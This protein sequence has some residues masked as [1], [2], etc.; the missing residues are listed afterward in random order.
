MSTPRLSD[1]TCREAAE[2][3]RRNGGNY[4]YGSREL[5]IARSTYQNRVRRA[6]E[7]GMLGYAPVLPGYAVTETAVQRD[8]KG[9]VQREWVRQKREPGAEF[10]PPE[11]HLIKG[12]SALVDPEGRTIAQWVKTR[13]DAQQRTALIDAI[14]EELKSYKATAKPIIVPAN[15]V[16]DMATVYAIGDHHLGLYTWGKETEG[17]DY[18]LAKGNKILRESME[19]LV[20]GVPSASTGIVLNLGDFIHADNQQNRTERSGNALDV[21][22]RYAKVLQVGVGLL[23]HCVELAARKH[24]KVIVRCLPGNHDP[25]TSLALSIALDKYFSKNPQIEV[26]CSPSPF[27]H[28]KFGKVFIAANHG[29][30]VKPDDMPGVMA[31]KWPK[32]WGDT[33]FRYAY[34]GHVHHRSKGGGEAHGVVWETFQTLSPR[35]AWHAASGYSAGRSMTAITHHRERGEIM[36]HTVQAG[37]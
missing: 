21:D 27:W 10:K 20:A 5:G 32:E 14:K 13:E 9:N 30:M 36:R 11:G 12:I 18:D 26:D 1:E 31:A 29:D 19:A 16:K 22:T 15:S 35:D 6:A 17:P 25:H 3:F 23:I 24:Q 33:N 34:F 28:W 4:E 8:H 2:V 7:R 37:L